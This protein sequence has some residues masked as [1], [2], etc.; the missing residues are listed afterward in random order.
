[1]GRRILVLGNGF[2]VAHDLPT[3]YKDFL[4][5][6]SYIVGKPLYD[7]NVVTDSLKSIRKLFYDKIQLFKIDVEEIKNNIWINYFYYRYKELGNNWIDFEGEIKEVCDYFTT[8]APGNDRYDDFDCS[9]KSKTPKFNEMV[10]GLES[11]I[12]ILD[13]YLHAVNDLSICKYY[14]QIID[15]MPTDVITLNYTN[16]FERVYYKYENVCYAHGTLSNI[17]FDERGNIISEESNSIVLGFNSLIEEKYEDVYYDFLKYYQMVNKDVNVDRY[18]N[19]QEK[20]DNLVMF[21]GHSLDKTDETFIQTIIDHSKK[22]F[23]LYHD[24]DAKAR[25]IRNLTRILRRSTFEKY[26]LTNS[27][28]IYFI[29]QENPVII[30]KDNINSTLT[31]ITNLFDYCHYGKNVDYNND[32]FND[33][34]TNIYINELN[35]N[36]IASCI[37]GIKNTLNSKRIIE[38]KFIK[39]IIDYLSKIKNE[40]DVIINEIK[41]SEP[42]FSNDWSSTLKFWLKPDA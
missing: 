16:T 22:V 26:T 4:Y 5:S 23:V 25:S 17:K 8:G 30:S 9:S 6:C 13:C 33:I 40:S 36:L 38:K 1:M 7:E 18:C 2:D 35:I 28:K 29:K 24:D 39:N 41:Y 11:L 19:I 10:E 31:N 42:A 20:N 37:S 32:V 14:Q 27:K 34:K 15:F 3:Q 12:K 21:F